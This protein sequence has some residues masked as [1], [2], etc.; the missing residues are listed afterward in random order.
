MK[1][2]MFF[3]E[4]EFEAECKKTQFSFLCKISIRFLLCNFVIVTQ[5]SNHR[6]AH[7]HEL[8][9][10]Q[11]DSKMNLANSFVRIF[12]IILNTPKNNY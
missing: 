2:K 1:K 6:K 10:W 5:Q 7:L 12:K 3:G 8:I 4:T 11:L 9:I